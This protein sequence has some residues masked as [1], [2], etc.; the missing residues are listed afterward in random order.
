MQSLLFAIG[1]E[2]FDETTTRLAKSIEQADWCKL[3]DAWGQDTGISATQFQAGQIFGPGQRFCN[4]IERLWQD[5]DSGHEAYGLE[6]KNW[7][8]VSDLAYTMLAEG[9]N[10]GS[11]SWVIIGTPHWLTERQMQNLIDDVARGTG[12]KAAPKTPARMVTAFDH[13]LD[14]PLEDR[15]SETLSW[16]SDWRRGPS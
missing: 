15:V 8:S 16:L 1:P 4:E 7:V 9:I 10:A 14:V 2:F 12:S 5:L 13:L 3:L 6:A 11:Q